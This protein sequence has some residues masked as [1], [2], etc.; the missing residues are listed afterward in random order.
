MSRDSE[1]T[2]LCGF[3]GKRCFTGRK[4]AR[5]ATRSAGNRMRIYLCPHCHYWHVTSMSRKASLGQ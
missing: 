5:A 4:D 1:N 2:K 3:G